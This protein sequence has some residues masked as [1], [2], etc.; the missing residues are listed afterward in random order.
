[1]EILI[2]GVTIGALVGS[3]IDTAM[4]HKNECI[5]YPMEE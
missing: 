5:F 3:G 2:Y 1:V 4:G